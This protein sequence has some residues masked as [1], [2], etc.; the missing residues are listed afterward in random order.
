MKDKLWNFWLYLKNK[1]TFIKN[2]N[3]KKKLISDLNPIKNNNVIFLGSSYGGWNFIDTKNLE[4][5]FVI[6]AGLGED[7]SFDTELVKKYKCK[8][9]LVDPTP[10]AIDHYN[11]IIKKSGSSKL[12]DFNNSGKED[13]VNYDLKNLNKKN[14]FLIERAL[15]NKDNVNLRFFS[16]PNKNHVSYSINNWQN[17][18]RQDT[19]FIR[20][21][22]ITVKSILK[23]FKI[24]NLELIK[25]DI[26][27]SEIETIQN[28]LQDNIYPKQILVEFDEL[29]IM[30]KT[31]KERF[32]ETHRL[33]ISKKYKVIKSNNKFPDFLYSRV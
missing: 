3:S 31:G 4:N 11:Q 33:L 18:Y 19:K 27:G 32:Y 2:F 8:V 24:K 12:Q 29:N 9:I 23:K 10:R 21:K 30:S 20:V 5:N 13:I 28:M 1:I 7:A 25:L 15:F 14:F 16:P 17:E 22:T 6:S 26:E